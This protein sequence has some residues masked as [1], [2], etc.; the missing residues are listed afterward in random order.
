LEEY[1]HKPAE[2]QPDTAPSEPLNRSRQ[3]IDSLTSQPVVRPQHRR[4]S[5]GQPQTAQYYAYRPVMR[6]MYRP[7][8]P[9]HYAPNNY[10]PNQLH[11][12]QEQPGNAP[13]YVRQQMEPT[14]VYRP[15][16]NYLPERPIMYG[17]LS[18]TPMERPFI[19]YRPERPLTMVPP[20]RTASPSYSIHSGVSS[21]STYTRPMGY[22]PERPR[23]MAPPERTS[24]PAHSI[25]SGVSSHS[26]FTRPMAY[27]P[28]RPPT[29]APPER[30]ASP[31]HSVH[32]SNSS[33]HIAYARPMP[34]RPTQP[35]Q[36]NYAQSV[37]HQPP[38]TSP[39]V[40]PNVP[41][42]QPTRRGSDASIN[43]TIL[44]HGNSTIVR[45]ALIP[46]ENLESYRQEVKKS[47]DPIKQFQ[48]AKQLILVAEGIPI[49]I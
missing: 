40:M 46:H 39:I 8:P 43:S 35:V 19:G 1:T 12:I 13:I 9:L 2:F 10:H 28:E 11:R 4:A 17:T 7:V 25:H 29:L 16:P 33:A 32:G 6:P 21:H 24:S 49:V 5:E 48:F 23:A 47:N 14:M 30:T 36:Y 44:T 27:R 22:R 45:E 20:E 15:V 34:T 42:G 3:S 37:Q 41:V 38:N 18:Y 26:T 31:A